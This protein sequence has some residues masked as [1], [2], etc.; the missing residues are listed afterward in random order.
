MNQKQKEFVNW[1]SHLDFTQFIAIF[2]MFWDQILGKY[3]KWYMWEAQKKLAGIFNLKRL[4]W[5]MKARQLGISEMMAMYAIFVALREA[6]SEI[7]VIS[8]KLPDAKYFLRKRV[9][10][11]LEAMYPLELEPGVKC[12][13]PK[14]EAFEGRITFENG[15]WIE[16]ASSDNEEV[17]SHTPRLILFDEVRSFAKNDA[18]EL[19]SAMLPAIREQPRSQ[20]IAV[21]TAKPGTWFNSMTKLIR[22]KEIE[23]VN[24][25]F[26]PGSANPKRTP[27][28]YEKES[29]KEPD[30]KMFYREY[31]RNEEDCFAAREGLVFDSFDPVEH[32]KPIDIEKIAYRCRFMIAYDHGFQ[33]L[34]AMLFFLFDKYENHLYL[35]DEQYHKRLQITEIAYNCR[36]K[37][38]FY[39]KFHKLPRPH[40][41]VADTACFGQTGQ[42][43]IAE[44]L[45]NI[46]GVSF[47]KSIK[48][49]EKGGIELVRSRFALKGITIDPRCVQAIRQISDLRWKYEYDPDRPD[50]QEEHPEVPVDV[51]NEAPDLLRYLEA[52][53]HALPKPKPEKPVDLHFNPK[54]NRHKREL[55]SKLFQGAGSTPAEF[56]EQELEA[57]QYL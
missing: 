41:A 54:F 44:V 42:R 33:H 3:V 13:W 48:H 14:Y 45:R 37:L 24:Y 7:I 53:L 34:A 49:N 4:I 32:V 21:S 17:R 35:F 52:E 12:A 30:K 29:K 16:A 27:E 50:M 19:W 8:K 46:M 26:M 20:L 2:G 1:L 11:K 57:W 56:T 6:K 51:D 23:G 43:P 47:K 5:V 9:L 18:A 55:R 15:S 36:K 10:T 38:N 22:I 31:P 39:K 40:L 28:W 25:F